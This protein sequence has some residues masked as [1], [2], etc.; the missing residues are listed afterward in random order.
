MKG[1]IS[2]KS[3]AITLGLAISSQSAYAI[4]STSHVVGLT[5]S[6]T[7]SEITLPVIPIGGP[8]TIILQD[9]SPWGS[10][11]NET[12][13]EEQNVPY[14]VMD[15]TELAGLTL[16]DLALVHTI[17]VSSNQSES[18]YDSVAAQMPLIELWLMIG[19]NSLLFHG[20]DNLS[21]STISLPKGVSIQTAVLDETNMV[22]D[23]TNPLVADVDETF[24][25]AFASHGYFEF[26]ETDLSENVVVMN[27]GS[28]PTLVDYC[29][30]RGRVIA[31]TITY[32]Y[33]YSN[34][35][36]SEITTILENEIMEG[37]T[38]PGCPN[39]LIKRFR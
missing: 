38:D 32:E 13:L 36:D 18:F 25:G 1:I 5:A 14:V 8:R 39:N 7:P 22:S 19:S 12:L 24:T 20:A 16:Q 30:G 9:S 2:L 6:N 26:S 10:N 34:F 11:A 23:A 29:Y 21:N 28:N 15:S 3:A 33:H 17:L 35:N 31:S 37:A 27:T 4:D